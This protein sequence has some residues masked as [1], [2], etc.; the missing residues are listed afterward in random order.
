MAWQFHG[1]GHALAI[2]QN[3]RAVC[4]VS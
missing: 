4:S 1:F 3:R 2:L